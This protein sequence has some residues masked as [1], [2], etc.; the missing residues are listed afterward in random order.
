MPE[1][2]D[3]RELAFRIADEAQAVVDR[4]AQVCA[5]YVPQTERETVCGAFLASATNAVATLRRLAPQ[6][7]TSDA[8]ADSFA[9]LA[10]AVLAASKDVADDL[11][12]RGWAGRFAVVVDDVAPGLI[13]D[14]DALGRAVEAVRDVVTETAEAVAGSRTAARTFA[15]AAVAVVV[16]VVVVVLAG[17]RTAGAITGAALDSRKKRDA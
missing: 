14:L 7:G 12:S 10:K 6:V 4:V 5:S 8:K 17:P 2:V 1:I 13:G 16:V 3:P 15:V 11:S 9:R